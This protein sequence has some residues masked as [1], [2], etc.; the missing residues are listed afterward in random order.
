MTPRFRPQL[1]T[2][3]AREVPAVNLFYTGASL[4]LTGTP[5]AT[6]AEVL[7]VKNV[8]GDDYQVTDGTLN[9]GTYRVTTDINIKLTKFD[10][11]IAVDVGGDTLGG[12]V[13]IDVGAGDTNPATLNRVFV[14]S[15]VAGGKVAGVVNFRNG[16]GVESFN[17][18]GVLQVGK[19]VRAIGPAVTSPKLEDKLT[20]ETRAVVH[21]DVRSDRITYTRIFGTVDGD[22][23]AYATGSPGGMGLDVTGTIHGDLIASGGATAPKEADGTYYYSY[24]DLGGT[25]GG[26]AVLRL[27]SGRA[28]IRT[29]TGGKIGGHLLYT[30]AD[31]V[32]TTFTLN[33]GSSV[34]KSLRYTAGNGGTNFLE[35]TNR[36]EG[37]AFFHLGGPATGYSGLILDGSV[38]KSV[39]VT[40]GA[41]RVDVYA[42]GFNW[43]IPFVNQPTWKSIGGDLTVKLGNGAN[44]LELGGKNSDYNGEFGANPIGGKLTYTGGTGADTVRFDGQ[45]TFQ[46]KLDLGA[47]TDTVAFTPMAA[48]GGLDV[49][50]GGDLDT[51]VPPTLITFP[52]KL[53]NL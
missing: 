11:F 47:G 12:N 50:F 52:V 45:S 34:G 23:I 9:L 3:E 16:S 51:W 10:N 27:T 53:K 46:A 33:Y 8:G 17:V 36:V 24:A 40:G 20:I 44:T 6:D 5:Q 41:K 18:S 4:T 28:N 48:V 38:G 32:D 22:V 25:I 39:T 2:L 21:G 37:D 30:A 26:D 42:R 13:L 35:L 1:S 43:G 14:A 7:R 49:D 29:A 19:D 15:G 31:G